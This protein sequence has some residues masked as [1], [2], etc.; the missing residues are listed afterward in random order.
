MTIIKTNSSH[1]KIVCPN[2]GCPLEDLGFP[3]K[4][5][6]EGRCPVSDAMFDYEVDLTEGEEEMGVDKEGKK[7]KITKY[8]ITGED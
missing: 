4:P 7:F 8:K 5:K 2:H 1:S 3:L 6:G